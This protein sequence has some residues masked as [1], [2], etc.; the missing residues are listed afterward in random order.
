MLIIT[1]THLNKFEYLHFDSIW[2]QSQ[3]DPL[4]KYGHLSYLVQVSPTGTTSSLTSGQTID[5]S[6]KMINL[7]SN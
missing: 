2:H 4:G 6:T 5:L 1:C 7:W 3:N